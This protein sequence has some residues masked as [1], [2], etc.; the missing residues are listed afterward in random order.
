MRRLSGMDDFFL[1]VE[2]SGL[3]MHVGCLAIYGLGP[4]FDGMGLIQP[5]GSY[6]GGIAR[7]HRDR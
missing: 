2:R 5:A 3:P 7:V 1:H 6:D 4:I